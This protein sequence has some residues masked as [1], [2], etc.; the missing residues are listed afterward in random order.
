MEP[1]KIISTKYYKAIC[2]EKEIDIYWKESK[3][4]YKVKEAK[5]GI[6]TNRIYKYSEESL[7]YYYNK[8]IY[9]TNNYDTNQIIIK[10]INIGGWNIKN[11]LKYGKLF[12][13]SDVNSPDV[14]LVIP[15]KEILNKP[16]DIF[17]DTD[18]KKYHY[19]SYFGNNTTLFDKQYMYVYCEDDDM[20]EVLNI[21]SME[22][23]CIKK[24]KFKLTDEE[25]YDE[26]DE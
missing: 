13:M 16:I 12:L 14:L 26:Y 5:L 8:N 6:I 19:D 23:I 3:Q 1:L 25:R 9:Y 17:N 7:I 21:D 2:Y 20:V 18:Y 10:N 24:V 11:Y 22:S 4:H 15:V